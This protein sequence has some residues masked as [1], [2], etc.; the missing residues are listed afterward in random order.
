MGFLVL[1]LAIELQSADTRW[2][3]HSRVGLVRV[4]GD[5]ACLAINDQGLKR[6]DPVLVVGL[7]ER[8]GRTFAAEVES[9][10]ASCPGLDFKFAHG[11]TFHVDT[12]RAKVLGAATRAFGTV[13]HTDGRVVFKLSP[14][15]TPHG[16]HFETCSEEGRV[17]VVLV[18]TYPAPGTEVWSTV[19]P[20]LVK[21]PPCAE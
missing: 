2:D 16:L 14:A 18:S 3:F 9:P 5:H 1:I 12:P 20:D 7:D 10:V 8:P 17:R 6:G 11:V 4:E 19:I 13:I 15:P 21:V